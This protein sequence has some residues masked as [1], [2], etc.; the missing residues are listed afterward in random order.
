MLQ[1]FIG[2]KNNENL[3]FIFEV[4]VDIFSQW[5]RVSDN[6]SLHLKAEPVINNRQIHSV[7]YATTEIP[8][9]RIVLPCLP[10]AGLFCQQP[11]VP[12]RPGRLEAHPF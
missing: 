5:V 7:Q 3:I 10:H 4:N 8:E 2:Y 11:A 9:N 12:W 1:R 6:I